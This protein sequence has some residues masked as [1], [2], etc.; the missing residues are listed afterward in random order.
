M[1]DDGGYLGG[2]AGREEECS[3]QR[4]QSQSG[5]ENLGRS[6]LETVAGDRAGELGKCFGKFRNN[7]GGQSTKSDNSRA[8]SQFPRGIHRVSGGGGGGGTEES[9]MMGAKSQR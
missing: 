4:Q 6:A 1:K 2:R 8:S 9:T 5:K 3:Q 7:A